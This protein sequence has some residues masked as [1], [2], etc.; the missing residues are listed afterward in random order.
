M[1][2]TRYSGDALLAAIK[3]SHNWSEVLRKIGLRV[4]GG[5]RAFIQQKATHLG[6]DTTHV[7]YKPRGRPR[8]RKAFVCKQCQRVIPI[9]EGG[10]PK[11]Y[12]SPEC[13]K[14]GRPISLREALSVPGVREKLREVQRRSW[15]DPQRHAWRTAGMSL[16][17]VAARRL[18]G[19]RKAA[20]SPELRAKRSEN[21]KR[22]LES[23]PEFR[24]RWLAASTK[25]RRARVLIETCARK[26][27]VPCESSRY[28]TIMMRSKWER[29]FALWLDRHGV[30][31]R[32]EPLR[33]VVDGHPYTPDFFVQSPL[34]DCYV[35]LHRV[36]TAK[37]GDTKTIR[38]EAA[39]KVLSYPVVL[40]EE[41]GIGAIRQML[42]KP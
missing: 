20:A 23:D 18:A 42:R 16:P 9:G 15:G 5:S 11:V 28:G 21:A 1:R 2:G 31:W 39:R 19:V 12:C 22:K 33:I 3:S 4:A 35:E 27:H 8:T 25:A 14:I 38:L 26:P 10:R 41:T 37:V 6:I 40:I 36:A 17:D 30:E 32:Y 7:K 34:G 29:D 24:E 13:M